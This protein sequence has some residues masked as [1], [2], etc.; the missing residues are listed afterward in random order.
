MRDGLL[1]RGRRARRLVAQHASQPAERLAEVA[2]HARGRSQVVRDEARVVAVAA[3]FGRLQCDA[4]LALGLSP[5]AQGDEAEAARVAALRT[6]DRALVRE[7]YRAVE[8]R[9]GRL[10]VAASA[11]DCRERVEGFGLALRVPLLV[12]KRRS[13]VE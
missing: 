2:A 1:R 6:H 13:A 10:A 7:L 9:E 4:K 12:Q 5:L 8:I 11:R 3:L